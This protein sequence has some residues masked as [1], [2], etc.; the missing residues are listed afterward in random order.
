MS[1]SLGIL[2][3]I[4]MLFQI[5]PLSPQTVP[6]LLLVFRL[7]NYLNSLHR[8][9]DHLWYDWHFDEKGEVIPVWFTVR[10]LLLNF[11]LK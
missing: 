3:F 5:L 1:S 9:P 7:A 8:Y 6:V 10:L 2:R 4:K 11:L